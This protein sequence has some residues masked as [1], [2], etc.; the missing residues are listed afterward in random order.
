MGHQSGGRLLRR[1]A[2]HQPEDQSQ[3]LRD[4]PPRHPVHQRRADRGQP[5]LVGRPAAA[6]SRCSTG[7]DARTIRRNGPAAH[8]NSRFTVSAQRNPE[9][10]AARRGCRAACRSP[11]SYSAAGAARWRRWCTRRATGSTACW[12]APRS[13]R[14]R[15]P[16]RSAR[17][18]SCAAIRWR[19]SRSAA[20]TSATTGGTGSTSA[21]SSARPPRIFHVNWFRRD[22]QGKFLWPGFGENL[23]VLAWMLDRC[24][25]K[26]RRRGHADRPPAAPRGSRHPRAGHQRRSARGAAHRRCGAVAQG[27]GGDPRVSRQVWQP[28]AGGAAGRARRHRAA[29]R[30]RAPRAT[31]SA[32]LAGEA[33][34]LRR[35]LLGQA[36]EP[37]HPLAA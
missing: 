14:R 15:P 30:T 11:P 24:A 25:G 10:L 35:A 12:S 23:R 4:D 21:R 2:G 13:P 9:L 18:A 28:P 6:A 17:S 32:L 8:P 27:S 1:G 20:T 5:A 37:D 7:R 22:A 3:R 31:A 26:A 36:A 16:P 19:C 34:R 29:A 33:D